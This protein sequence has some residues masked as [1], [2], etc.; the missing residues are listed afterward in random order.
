MG[1][2]KFL[3]I[4]I[5]Y[6]FNSSIAFAYIDPGTGA[7]LIQTLVAIGATVIFYLGWPIR[8]IKSLFSKKKKVNKEDK[9]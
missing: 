2:I 6:S 4:I 9:K 3:F 5:F 1:R 8:F 7:F